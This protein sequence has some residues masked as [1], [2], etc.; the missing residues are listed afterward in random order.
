[1]FG[2]FLVFISSEH[3]KLNITRRTKDW[4]ITH[5]TSKSGKTNGGPNLHMGNGE[6]SIGLDFWIWIM[7]SCL[8]YNYTAVPLAH[9][10]WSWTSFLRVLWCSVSCYLARLLPERNKL[11]VHKRYIILSVLSFHWRPLDSKTSTMRT[12]CGVRVRAS[13]ILA[14][15][16]DSR[17]HGP[18]LKYLTTLL[19]PSKNFQWAM[20]SVSLGAYKRLKRNWKQCLRG[21]S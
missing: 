17:R 13:V 11:T 21:L 1:M 3:P 2:H 14:G 15:K 18:F 6:I 4:V 5:V 9:T 7:E 8:L 20:F 10:V 19:C 16:R 12:I